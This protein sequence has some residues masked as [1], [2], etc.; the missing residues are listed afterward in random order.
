MRLGIIAIG[1]RLEQ[2]LD[3]AG[4]AEEAGFSTYATANIFGHDAIGS[5]ALAAARTE[6][7]ELMTAVVPIYA[8]HP[9]AMAQQALTAAVAS[10][11]RFTLGVGLSHQ[12]VIEG[13]IGMSYERPG[14]AMREY[15][16]V[17]LPL[18]RGEQVT[19]EGERYTFRG[20]LRAPDARYPIPCLIAAMAPVMLRLA[21]ERT[22]GTVL[23]M[24]GAKAIR[25]HVAP[26]IR[27][28]AAGAGRPEPRIVC[29]LP[30]ALTSNARAAREAADRQF[31]NYGRLPSYRAMLDKQ[32]AATPGAAALVGDEA[33]LDAALRELEES[34]ATEFNGA[35]FDAGDGSV[36]RTREFLASRAAERAGARA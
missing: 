19:H 32:G 20:M 24:T 16:D 33:A 7:I 17:L 6:R 25:E 26:K 11:G 1:G 8:R 3:D 31:E 30:I 13:M 2:L 15:V 34:G 22:D 14:A 9:M 23:W 12:V 27:R 10:G 5:L 21:G 35:P 28:A 29:G 18:L 4:W 36:E